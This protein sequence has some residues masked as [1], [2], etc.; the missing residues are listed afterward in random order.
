MALFTPEEAL[1]FH[2]TG[3]KGKTEVVPT[4]PCMPQK[5]LTL[6]YSPGVAHACM[7]IHKDPSKVYRNNF[8]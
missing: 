5:Q 8:V 2:A 6:A 7:A 4:K 1:H 3:R